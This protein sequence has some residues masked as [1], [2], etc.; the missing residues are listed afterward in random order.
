MPRKVPSA[1]SRCTGTSRVTHAAGAGGYTGP[2]PTRASKGGPGVGILDANRARGGRAGA[3]SAF[4]ARRPQD[5]F[6][7][8]VDNSNAPFLPPPPVTHPDPRS[9]VPSPGAH[10]L[11]EELDDLDDMRLEYCLETDLSKL[12]EMIKKARKSH[13]ELLRIRTLAQSTVTA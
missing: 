5:F 13:A 2:A 7:V 11:R 10:P 1:T 8:P 3:G 4:V 9:Y 12:K 6:A